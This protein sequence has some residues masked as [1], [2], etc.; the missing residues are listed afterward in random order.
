[1]SGKRFRY[2]LE[3]VLLTRKWNLDTLMR[4][5]SDQNAA[6]AEHGKAEAALQ[7]TFDGAAADWQATMAAGGNQSVDPF[8]RSTRYLDDLS[9]QLREHA[10]RSAE[11]A[12]LRDELIGHITM[13]QRGVEAVEEH[14]DDMHSQFVQQRLS[15][16]FKVADDQWNTLQ[17]GASVNGN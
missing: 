12:A 8:V 10:A 5:L 1:M 14:R 17:S 2:A 11:M 13:A 3:P 6:I 9:L 16:D 7:H 15:S 4:S